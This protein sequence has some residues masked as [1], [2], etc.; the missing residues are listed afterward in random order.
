MSRSPVV[1]AKE[2]ITRSEAITLLRNELTKFTSDETSICQA[3]ADRG[4]FCRG[5][6]Q[7]S[8]G[9]LRRTYS[10]LSK[11]HP[12]TREELED[13]ANSWQ[14]A[15]QEADQLPLACD[16]QQKEHDSCNGW[17]DF[18]N[19]ELA[20]FCLELTGQTIVVA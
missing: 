14:L 8:D 2:N 3:A 11:R 19:D 4:I 9:G 20:R 16:V 10:W 18:S 1:P 15:R 5:F 7:Y 12:G 6:Q 17:D 13:L